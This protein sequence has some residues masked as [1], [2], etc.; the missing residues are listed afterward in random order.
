MCFAIGL[1]SGPFGQNIQINHLIERY[2]YL[3]LEVEWRIKQKFKLVVLRSN[4]FNAFL[5]ALNFLI[6]GT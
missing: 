4:E 6:R 3:I 2:V 1:K 5:K